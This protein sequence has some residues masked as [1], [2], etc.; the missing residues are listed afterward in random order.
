MSNSEFGLLSLVLVVLL[1]TAHF[2]GYL[3]ARLRQPRVI[4]EILAGVLLGPSVLAHFAP[5]STVA[6][7]LAG[8]AQSSTAASH[9]SA[10]GFLFNLGLLLLMFVSGAETKN[11]FNNQDRRELTWLGLV[12]TG[13]PFIIALAVSPLMPKASLMGSANQPTS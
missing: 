8:Q 7:A 10:L 2:L 4:G 13:L 3:F 12:G 6:I 5:S 11:L 1:G 9:Q